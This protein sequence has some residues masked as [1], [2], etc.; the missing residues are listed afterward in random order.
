[1]VPTKSIFK[2]NS[3]VVICRFYVESSIK[4]LVYESETDSLRQGCCWHHAKHLNF[5]S[6][7]YHISNPSKGLSALKNQ[8]T[9][10]MPTTV[11]GKEGVGIPENKR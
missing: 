10:F 2:T 5:D 7:S 9:E 6:K 4:I 11:P 3:L 8:R 1:M